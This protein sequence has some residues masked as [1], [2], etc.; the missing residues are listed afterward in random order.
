MKR[1]YKIAFCIIATVLTVACG[2]D[3]RSKSETWGFTECYEDFLWSKYEPEMMERKIEIELNPDACKMFEKYGAMTFYIS[4]SKDRFEA[5]QGVDLYFDGEKCEDYHFDIDLSNVKDD[6]TTQHIQLN[7]GIQFTDV[8]DVEKYTLYFGSELE[9]MKYAST[10]Y[11]DEVPYRVE[12]EDLSIDF[13][14]IASDGIVLEKSVIMNPL[15]KGLIWTMIIL[16]S[17]LIISI[18]ISRLSNPPVKVS[19]I[20]ITGAYHKQLT[21]RGYSMVVLTSK[22][23][24][25]GFLN[26]L[27]KGRILYEVNPTWH[28]DVTISPRNNKS[29]TMRYDANSYS[30]DSR[31]LEKG[32]NYTLNDLKERTKIEIRVI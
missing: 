19:R 12:P 24:K 23:M 9:N 15:K 21:V 8:A 1:L 29:V 27:Y 22:R 28:S 11:I 7:I 26:K 4:E 6:G 18:I 5:P 31:V 10:V 20:A 25:Q 2:E 3:I 30:C 16:T 32:G 13:V 17:I 14:S